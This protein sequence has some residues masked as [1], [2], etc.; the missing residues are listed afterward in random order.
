MRKIVFLT[1]VVLV[2]ISVIPAVGISQVS[3][4]NKLWVG[5]NNEIIKADSTIIR[6]EL[7]SKKFGNTRVARFYSMLLNVMVD[8][9]QCHWK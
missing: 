8:V 9:R 1:I 4:A 5:E 2:F 7:F 3:I 6:F